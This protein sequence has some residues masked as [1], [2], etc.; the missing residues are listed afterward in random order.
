[1]REQS[2]EERPALRLSSATS[3]PLPSRWLGL[4]LI[5]LLVAGRRPGRRRWIAPQNPY[6]L[7]PIGHHRRP[8][9][10]GSQAGSAGFTF[11]IGSDGQGRD[12]LSGILYGLRLSRW[13]WAIGSAAFAAVLGTSLGL[14]AAYAGGRTDSRGR[15]GWWICNCPSPPSWWR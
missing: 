4:V 1:M 14:L 11:L 15:C 7:S 2:R 3:P 13:W 10:T 9:A 5:V 6:D 8:P 12:M